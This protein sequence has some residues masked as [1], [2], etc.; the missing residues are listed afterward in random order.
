MKMRLVFKFTSL[1][2]TLYFHHYSILIHLSKA[3]K[4]ATSRHR[5]FIIPLS[6]SCK[7]ESSRYAVTKR[8]KGNTW[9]KNIQLNQCLTKERMLLSE[10]RRLNN[11][12]SEDENITIAMLDAVYEFKAEFTSLLCFRTIINRE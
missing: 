2:F 5:K 1:E 8:K 4:A 12:H 3:I 11:L 6:F 7:R 9:R 10:L